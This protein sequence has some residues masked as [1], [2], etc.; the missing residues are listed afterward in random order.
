MIFDSL[1][2]I[3]MFSHSVSSNGLYNFIWIIWS[4]FYRDWG[5]NFGFYLGLIFSTPLKGIPE[6]SLEII[7]LLYVLLKRSTGPVL[8]HDP[9]YIKNRDSSHWSSQALCTDIFLNIKL[10]KL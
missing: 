3:Q 2:I 7:A 6:D 9:V 1:E 4:L 8:G 5:I 10:A